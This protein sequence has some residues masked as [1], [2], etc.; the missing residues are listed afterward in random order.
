MNAYSKVSFLSLGGLSG[1]VE[2]R[3]FMSANDSD[4]AS[5]CC[6]PPSQYAPHFYF[7]S[8][9]VCTPSPRSLALQRHGR[10][11]IHAEDLP[12]PGGLPKWYGPN[13]GFARRLG[14]AFL[15]FFRT[16]RYSGRSVTTEAQ[17]IPT[18]TSMMP[19]MAL[20]TLSHKGFV[21]VVEG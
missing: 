14:A 17:A 9:V 13:R 7:A 2:P 18:L 20:G 15:R 3:V 5:L 16:S 12:A 10:Q 19:K 21:E 1:S 11:V 4:F 8:I 6:R